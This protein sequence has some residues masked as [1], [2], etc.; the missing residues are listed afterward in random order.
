MLAINKY[1]TQSDN[2]TNKHGSIPFSMTQI[3]FNEISFTS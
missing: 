2:G 1:N 3:C